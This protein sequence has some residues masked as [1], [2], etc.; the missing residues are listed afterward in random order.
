MGDKTVLQ[1][2]K[3]TCSYNS[4][5]S[6]QDISF[7]I[8]PGELLG[9]IGPNGAGKTTL[10]KV[11]TKVLKP[12]K[13]KIIFDGKDI[14]KIGFKEFARQV[15][16][17]PQTSSAGVNMTVEELVLLGRIPHRR[18]FQFLETKCDLQVAKQAMVLAGVFELKDRLLSELSG[19]ERQLV[20]IARA[21]A[22]EPQLLLLDEPT[23]HLDIGHQVKILD[24]VRKLNH[25]NGLTIIIVLHDLNL[26][27]LYCDILLLLNK[28]KIHSMGTPEHIL[29]YS[30]IE[31]VYKTP[32]VVEQNPVA[33]KPLV[34]LV[35]EDVLTLKKSQKNTKK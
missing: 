13:G 12:Q 16:F 28:G 8:N 32:V 2:E 10:L 34:C 31:E 9:V 17:V 4:A 6:L 18:Q 22:Q 21:L 5:F 30:V 27:S 14:N 29:S 33:P 35:P 25:E 20:T 19:G 15:A 7:K 23:A 26:A 1:V 3:L 24:L 11:I